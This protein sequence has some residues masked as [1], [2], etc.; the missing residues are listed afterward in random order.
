MECTNLT[1]CLPEEA[2]RQMK[3][4][5][6]VPAPE[7]TKLETGGMGRAY[8]KVW[9]AKPLAL[10]LWFWFEPETKSE[11][12]AYERGVQAMADNPGAKWAVS[13]ACGG[14]C[15]GLPVI[16]DGRDTLAFSDLT[17]NERSLVVEMAAS[18][19]SIVMPED[20][21]QTLRNL[22]IYG[23][24]REVGPGTWIATSEGR[25]ALE[26]DRKAARVKKLGEMAT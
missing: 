9:R 20:D 7:A 25:A 6:Q 13:E 24:V 22:A 5:F 23:Y 2:E 19:K 14:E 10:I 18:K 12:W 21:R 15:A 26:A 17:E 3:H 11:Q 4:L 1:T 8:I 16:A